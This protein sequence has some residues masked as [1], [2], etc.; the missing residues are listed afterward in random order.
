MLV[1]DSGLIHNHGVTWSHE[2]FFRMAAVVA[3]ELE[4]VS[5]TPTEACKLPTAFSSIPGPQ[6]NPTFAVQY[7]A[8]TSVFDMPWRSNRG[9]KLASRLVLVIFRVTTFSLD[10]LPSFLSENSTA[11]GFPGRG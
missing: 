10:K 9:L 8:S 3:M 2:A 11:S 1:E 6:F 5:L 4:E 7:P